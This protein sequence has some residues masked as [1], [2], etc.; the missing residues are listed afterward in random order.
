MGLAGTSTHL[1]MQGEGLP[2][3]PAREDFRDITENLEAGV[4]RLEVIL[5]IDAQLQNILRTQEQQRSTL[6]TH[7]VAHTC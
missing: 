2:E 1:G 7:S 5:V 4:I 6:L 3:Q